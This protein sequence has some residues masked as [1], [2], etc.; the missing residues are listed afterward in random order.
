MSGIV[1][2]IVSLL[3]QS[4]VTYLK[5]TTGYD[6]EILYA[7]IFRDTIEGS[8]WLKFKNFSLNAGAASYSFM[9]VLYRILD[10]VQ[11]KN[12]LE[13]GLG[14]TTKLTSQY[15]GHVEDAKVT[16]IESDQDWINVFSDKLELND[17]IKIIQKDIETF[18]YDNTDNLRY[19]EFTAE[20]SDEKFDFIIIDG[21]NGFFPETGEPLDYSRTNIWELI[22]N[23]LADDF[24]II[25]DDYERKGEQNTI[26]QVKMLLVQYGIE[27]YE[28]TLVGLKQQHI[29][30][31]E[32]YKFV[33]WY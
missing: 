23:N 14:Q 21:P 11:P 18:E 10:E 15:A 1:N 31:S 17:N 33:T 13:L 4:I 2:F 8:N 5:Q 20:I 27:F 32:G 19:K 24:I 7:N 25:I 29:I 26:K 22:P 6:R 28:L 3:P 30:V 12:T 16:V 9:Y